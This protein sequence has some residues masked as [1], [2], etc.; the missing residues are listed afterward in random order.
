MQSFIGVGSNLGDTKNNIKTAL[1][2]LISC[3]D[4]KFIKSSSFYETEPWGITDQPKFVNAVWEIDTT[5]LPIQLFKVLKKIE[6][7]MGRE[8][9]VRYGPRIIDLDI[10]FY[11]NLIYQDVH[12]SIPHPKL[13]E[14]SFVLFPMNEIASNYLHP[15][16][17][18]TILELKTAVKNDL[19]IK[20]VQN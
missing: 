4:I 1:D 16:L 5:L 20:L 11:D 18:L 8:K 7:E 13:T 15:L 14:R 19:G 12:L 3:E 2:L 17:N 9:S 6:R 10:L